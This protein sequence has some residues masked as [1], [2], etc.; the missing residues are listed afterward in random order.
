MLAGI[1]LV[2]IER[3]A[4]DAT[5]KAEGGNKTRAAKIL[6]IG[7]KTLYRKIEAYGITV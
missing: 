3:R 4:I 7:L 5:L 1:P 2:E 6:G